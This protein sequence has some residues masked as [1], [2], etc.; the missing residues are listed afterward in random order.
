MEGGSAPWCFF[1]EVFSLI[2]ILSATALLTWLVFV[3]HTE[4]YS[5]R[6]VIPSI[7]EWLQGIV[8]KYAH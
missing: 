3:L 2:R 4:I 5:Y 7:T 8:G 1:A 6:P